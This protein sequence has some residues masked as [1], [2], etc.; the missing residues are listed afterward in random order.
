MKQYLRAF[1]PLYLAAT[2]VVLALTLGT[3]GAVS[4]WAESRSPIRDRVIVI[5]AG[6][7]GEDGGAVSCTGVYESHLNLQI[8]LRLDACL[9][10]L[11]YDTVMIRTADVSVYTEGKT[12]AAKK[13]SDLR[14]RVKCVNGAG[15]AVLVSIHQNLFVESRYSGAQV[16]YNRIDGAKELAQALQ[17]AFIATVNPDSHRAVKAAEG[18]YLMENVQKPAVLVECGFL[19]N[20]QEEALLR[21]DDYQKQIACLIASVSASFLSNA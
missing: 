14:N 2:A 4:A 12:I 17:S 21:T 20:P 9:H 10:L 7:G 15:N 13:A 19:S 8:A 16:F 11:G 1:W 3:S 5:D 18:L 6:H